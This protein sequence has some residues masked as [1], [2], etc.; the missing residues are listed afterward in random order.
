MSQRI[1]G[2]DYQCLEALGHLAPI[3]DPARW[4]AAVGQW[5]DRRIIHDR[6][7]PLR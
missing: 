1:P 6:Q 3:E 7:E 2:A 4:A 5:C